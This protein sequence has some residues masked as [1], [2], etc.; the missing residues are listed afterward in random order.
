MICEYCE[1]AF[2]QTKRTQ[3]FCSEQCRKKAERKRYQQRQRQKPRRRAFVRYSCEHCGADFEL[4]VR[5]GPEPKYCS[6]RCRRLADKC[7]VAERRR[8]RRVQ[9]DKQKEANRPRCKRC[10]KPL[11]HKQK[12]FCS[13]SC[14]NLAHGAARKRQTYIYVCKYCGQEYET[15]YKD[16]NQYCSREHAF[17]AKR[18]K[19]QERAEAKAAGI[20]SYCVISYGTCRECGKLFVSKRRKPQ[21]TC[22]E[23]CA[24]A[25]ARRLYEECMT[26]KLKERTYVCQQ[27][28]KEFVAPYGDKRHRF[29][30]IEC[31]KRHYLE[32]PA[33]KAQKT[34]QRH[35]RRAMKY[36]NGPIDDIDFAVVVERDAGCCGICGHKVDPVLKFPHPMSASL[37]HIIPLARGGPHRWENVQLAHLACNI[38]KG[39]GDRNQLRLAMINAGGNG[40]AGNPTEQPMQKGRND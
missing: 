37:D 36:G 23:E 13:H 25:R 35:K 12:Q 11:Y 17:A 38:K 15:A 8:V 10:G 18:A 7:R 33:G 32:S 5:P 4:E 14:A 34:R 20:G 29:C 30:S 16:R 27:C 31:S 39:A 6:D 9:R 22:G 1:K 2:D 24:K 21:L 26:Q 28:G 40:S 3:R 19:A